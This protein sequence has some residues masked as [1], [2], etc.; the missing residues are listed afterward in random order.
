MAATGARLGEAARPAATG[1]RRRTSARSRTDPSTEPSSGSEARSGWGIR[2]DDVPPLVADAGD[3]VD[4]SVGVVDVAEH[5]PVL[6]PEPGQ[7]LGVADVVALEMVDRNPQL[8]ARRPPPGQHRVRGV[9]PHLHRGAEEAEP[10]VLL[11]G[12]R[13]QAGLGQHLESVADPDH[14]P[15]VGGEAAHRLH[16]RREP[17]DGAGSQVIAVGEPARQDERVIAVERRGRR[18]T[19]GQRRPP[20]FGRP[21][22]HRAR[23]WC[24]GT[25]PPRDAPPFRP[26]HRRRLGRTGDRSTPR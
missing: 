9:D 19:P 21:G 22:R 25:S 1:R 17:G 23:S 5:H 2:P 13:Q 11:Q 14:R 18:A 24:P 7:R 4:R 26:A 10:P 12:A 8:G 16:H 6:V 3:V 20:A 15:P